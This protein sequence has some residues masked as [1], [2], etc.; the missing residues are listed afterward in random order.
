MLANKELALGD[1]RFDELT[2]AL[3]TAASRRQ[4]LTALGATVGG[5][6]FSLFG[7]HNAEAMVPGRCRL[8]GQICRQDRECCDFYCDRGTGRCACP[9]GTVAG[10]RTRRC[11]K[12]YQRPL[13]ALCG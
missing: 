9:P 13:P 1:H 11:L 3:A 12:P 5:A 10:E 6:A 4:T 7:V 2:K 8:V